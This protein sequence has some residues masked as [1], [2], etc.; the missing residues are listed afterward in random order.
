MV[1]GRFLYFGD[2][3]A[4]PIVIVLLALIT[5]HGG[6]TGLL[7]AWLAATTAGLVSWTFLEYVIH[8]WI[9]HR[10]PGIKRY[11][12]AHH[13]APLEMIGAPSFVSLFI[14]L[15]LCYLPLVP[16]GFATASGFASGII[17]GYMGYMLVHHATHHW[18]LKPGTWLYR[19]RLHH[20]A[21]HFARV[22]GN[23][24]IVTSF[25]DRV[26]GTMVEK[27]KRAREGWAFF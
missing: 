6:G 19:A 13:D 25:W 14:I 11:H 23:Y 9:Y 20:M 3:V 10:V 16:L 21:H 18:E 2:F 7:A 26:F 1:L 15:A 4:G 5:A 22:E 8:R 27:R 24:G 12:D 17:L